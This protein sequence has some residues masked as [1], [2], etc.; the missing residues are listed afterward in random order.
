MNEPHDKDESPH[1]WSW[2]TDC[3]RTS[4]LAHADIFYSFNSSI[5]VFVLALRFGQFM[6]QIFFLYFQV[7]LVINFI[8]FYK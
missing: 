4:G 2:R 1:L 8:F 7:Y 6:V 5:V 3:Q